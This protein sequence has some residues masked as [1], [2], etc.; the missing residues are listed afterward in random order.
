MDGLCLFPAKVGI[1]FIDNMIK[2]PFTVCTLIWRVNINVSR[3]GGGINGR[4]E[5]TNFYNK[6]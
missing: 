6:L 1:F 4:N 5:S 3:Q 2:V